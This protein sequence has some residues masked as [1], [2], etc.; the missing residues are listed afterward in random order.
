M[1]D[2]GRSDDCEAFSQ[3]EAC[4][5]CIHAC[6]HTC[7]DVCRVSETVLALIW[8]REQCEKE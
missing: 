8:Q 3:L 7:A 1:E 6:V 2:Q 5:E 4:S